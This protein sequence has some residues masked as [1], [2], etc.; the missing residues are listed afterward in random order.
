MEWWKTQPE[1]WEACRKGT[2]DPA[3][4]M[5]EFVSWCAKLQERGPL[6]IVGY[7]VTFDFMFLY[8]YTMAFGGLKDGEKCPFGFQGLDI[9][10]LAAEK[11]G[12]SYRHATKKNMPKKWFIGTPKHNHEALQDAIGQG[13]LFV[14]MVNDNE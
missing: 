14:N 10:T 2:R 3:D 12:I 5:P 4:V 7:P 9:K 8:F 6:V 1:A 13:I 11:L